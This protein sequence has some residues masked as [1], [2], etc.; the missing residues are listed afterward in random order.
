[1][2]VSLI[3]LFG[4]F[5]LRFVPIT[6]FWAIYSLL[7][8][9]EPRK[10][11]LFQ[12]LIAANVIISYITALIILI[13]LPVA[14]LNYF[15]HESTENSLIPMLLLASDNN[16]RLL[17]KVNWRDYL[18]CF[19]LN[20][21]LCSKKKVI[22]LKLMLTATQI[23][24]LILIMIG[25]IEVF[26]DY[27]SHINPDIFDFLFPE[28]GAGMFWGGIALLALTYFFRFLI[29]ATNVIKWK[30]R[31]LASNNFFSSLRDC[32]IS[33]SLLHPYFFLSPE[34]RKLVKNQKISSGQLTL[35][36]RK[37]F[38]ENKDVIPDK[39]LCNK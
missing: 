26:N 34:G 29:P 39:W 16:F 1:M 15:I 19:L 4:L 37:V 35:L 8:S 30:K 13:A 11:T 25:G 12:L 10:N 36:L 23:V 31:I 2:L 5:Y 9:W 18:F 28:V 6:I 17:G 27:N 21:N 32:A 14:I 33:L 20:E 3:F 38:I 7:F 22:A 24:A